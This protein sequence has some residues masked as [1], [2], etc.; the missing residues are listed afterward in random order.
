[1][2]DDSI[3]IG[4]SNELR[5]IRQYY[6]IFTV[7][8]NIPLPPQQLTI[9]IKSKLT[10]M[11]GHKSRHLTS[12]RNPALIFNAGPFC[13]RRFTAG[14]RPYARWTVYTSTACTMHALRPSTARARVNTAN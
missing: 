10:P 5:Q 6:Y 14:S 4:V 9:I 3:Y 2:T 11:Q 7:L 8:F 1:M 13:C 12:R